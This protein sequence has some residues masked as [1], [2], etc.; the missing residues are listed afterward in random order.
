MAKLIIYTVPGCGTCARAVR[1]LTEDGVAF[2]E[3]DIHKNDQWY[4]EASKLA[5]SVPILIRDGKVE[6]G[7]KGDMGCPFQ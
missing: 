7:W 2:E 6:L 1:E 4:E 5:V 3:R